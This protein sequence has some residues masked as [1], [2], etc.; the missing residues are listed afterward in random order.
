[1][2]CKN[3]GAAMNQGDSFCTICGTDQNA[4]EVLT[5]ESY[6]AYTSQPAYTAPAL[7]HATN[8]SLLKMIFLP[9]ITFGIYSM[10]IWSRIA[11]ELNIVACRY[12]GKKTCPF[13]SMLYLTMITFGVYGIVWQHKFCNRLGAEVTRRGYNYKFSASDFWLWNV[14]GSFIV[15]GPFIYLHKLMKCMNMINESYNIY[16]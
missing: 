2:N 3:C 10:V 11:D 13:F 14:L 15:V 9:M 6:N 4:T 16:G 8:R 12:D 1:M 7:K 5:A